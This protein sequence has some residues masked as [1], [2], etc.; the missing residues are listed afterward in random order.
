MLQMLLAIALIATVWQCTSAGGYYGGGHGNAQSFA[1][2]QGPVVGHAQPVSVGYGHGQ[3][4]GHGHG[5]GHDQSHGHSIDYI[6]SIT[7]GLHVPPHSIQIVLATLTKDV[8]WLPWY[9]A[10]FHFWTLFTIS[11]SEHNTEFRR[12]D[13]FLLS[14]GKVPVCIGHCITDWV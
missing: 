12:L 9:L 14:G 6:V 3:G 5:H 11:Y 4:H 13:L 8:L 1:H 2:F 10:F 7:G